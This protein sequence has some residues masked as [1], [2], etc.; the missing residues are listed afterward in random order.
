MSAASASIETPAFTRRTLDWDRSIRS[1]GIS[2]APLRTIWGQLLPCRLLHDGPPGD[3]LSAASP[4]QSRRPSPHSPCG[5]GPG[6]SAG[7]ASAL[8]RLPPRRWIACIGLIR[9]ELTTEVEQEVCGF[10]GGAGRADEDRKST[11]LNSSHK[12]EN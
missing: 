9:G 1:S 12:C 7:G 6:A 4:S 2:R 8:C 10:R 11:R 5:L 3:S